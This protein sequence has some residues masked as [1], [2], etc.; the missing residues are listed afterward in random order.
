MIPPVHGYILKKKLILHS[1]KENTKI[2]TDLIYN[3]KHV[4]KLKGYPAII[5]I[6]LKLF[7]PVLKLLW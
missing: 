5:G 2:V 7:L 3:N 1:V 4:Q 6:M